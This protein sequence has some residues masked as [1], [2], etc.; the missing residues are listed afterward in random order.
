M[1]A[2][3][4]LF[5]RTRYPEF[6]AQVDGAASETFTSALIRRCKDEFETL[7]LNLGPTQE[8]GKE[9]T[10]DALDEMFQKQ[11]DRRF[12]TLQFLGQLYLRELLSF[13]V[14]TE[15][16][17]RLLFESE[18]PEE[19]SIESFCTLLRGIGTMLESSDQGKVSVQQFM[20]R[21]EDLAIRSDYNHRIRV[22]M[23]DALEFRTQKGDMAP[24]IKLDR[25]PTIKLDL[26]H[27]AFF[28]R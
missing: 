16:M 28:E 23:Q 8:Q 10:A 6:P 27:T 15:V 24:W 25:I 11:K 19:H 5:L 26:I 17:N 14:V 1:C 21:L 9:L 7:L 20:T 13:D 18:A 22:I 12:A 2:E 4:C 3:L